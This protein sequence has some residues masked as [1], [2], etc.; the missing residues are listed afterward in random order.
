[1]NKF[2]ELNEQEITNLY[3]NLDRYSVQ[4]KAKIVWAYDF[5][6][7]HYDDFD[8]ENFPLPQYSG[9]DVR[10]IHEG[11]CPEC[12]CGLKLESDRPDWLVK[13]LEQWDDRKMWYGKCRNGHE[14]TAEPTPGGDWVAYW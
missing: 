5:L 3:E 13:S 10:A 2:F 12:G 14:P 1:M 6:V 7:A 4:I 8:G 9:L 11:C